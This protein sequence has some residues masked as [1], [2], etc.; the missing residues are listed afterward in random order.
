MQEHIRR[1]HPDNY[2]AK[3]P[4]TEESFQAMVNVVP[5]ARPT[6][7]LLPSQ[8]YLNSSTS[9][10]GPG[11]ISR[12]HSYNQDHHSAYSSPAPPRTFEESYPATTNAA[13]VAVALAA[14][15]GARQESGWISDTVGLIFFT[16]LPMAD[17]HDPG[18]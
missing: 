4:A 9:P 5:S 11:S 8:H 6:P 14:L 1:A 17:Y 12:L 7:T 16:M 3:L 15:R 13:T 2:I 10:D 18:E